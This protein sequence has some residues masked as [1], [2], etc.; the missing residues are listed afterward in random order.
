M[1]TGTTLKKPSADAKTVRCR[2]RS[3][4]SLSGR[5]HQGRARPSKTAES[6]SKITSG[7]AICDEPRARSTASKTLIFFVKPG[8]ATHSRSGGPPLTVPNLINLH[9]PGEGGG[10][11]STSMAEKSRTITSQPRAGQ[12]ISV[13]F[14]TPTN[15]QAVV[16]FAEWRHDQPARQLG[17][18]G[19]SPQQHGT[20]RHGGLTLCAGSEFSFGGEVLATKT[21]R[22]GSSPCR[23]WDHPFGNPQPGQPRPTSPITGQRDW[24]TWLPPSKKARHPLSLDRTLH[25][26]EGQ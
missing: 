20:V 15:I 8:G 1:R 24:L 22:G 14:K 2:L 18:L 7:T 4:R 17:R 10:G 11:S 5:R 16:E 26:V 12:K 6:L 13:S 19:P 3:P 23:T 21:W 25:G 9:R